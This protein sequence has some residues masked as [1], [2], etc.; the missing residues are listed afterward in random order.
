ME[1]VCFPNSGTAASAGSVSIN[2]YV[3]GG[4]TGEEEEE[5]EVDSA[6]RA[7]R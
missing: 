7:A 2:N 3:N 6:G 4:E 1:R 5:E